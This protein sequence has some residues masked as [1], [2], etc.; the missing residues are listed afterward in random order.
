MNIHI[1]KIARLIAAALLAAPLA[2]N[3]ASVM[4]E[5][6]GTITSATGIYASAGPTVTGTYTI[7]VAAEIPSQSLLPISITSTW[8]S[9]ANGGSVYEKPTPS[10]LVFAS[11]L[12][13]GGVTYSNSTPGSTG[14]DSFV[15]GSV[16]IPNE[17]I[18]GDQE[19]SGP[20]TYVYSQF[21]LY[22]S[23]GST[24][25]D[26]NGL[27]VFSNASGGNAGELYSNGSSSELLYTITSM[28]PVPL[29]AAL[30]LML[31]GIAGLGAF[32]R[33]RRAG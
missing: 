26:V 7:D 15:E 24:P 11:T 6:T 18:A 33:N 21:I 2:V 1:G 23:S 9:E 22:G 31:S 17:Y 28:T 14:S 3:A 20:G 5:F 8:I 32:V 4:Y 19:Y 10:A 12:N 13:S 30:W 29:P 25:W 27:P 16:G